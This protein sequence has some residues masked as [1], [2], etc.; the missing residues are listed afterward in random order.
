MNKFILA[1]S[2]LLVWSIL[3]SQPA[4][5]SEVDPDKEATI[6]IE[7]HEEDV[8]G[9]EQKEKIELKGI[10]FSQESD[11]FKDIWV[12]IASPANKEWKIAYEG[13]Y[14]PKLQFIDFNHDKV[15]DILYQSATGGSGGLYHYHLHTLK[16]EK[17]KN[18]PLPESNYTKGKFKDNFTVEITIY[19]SEKPI[20]M[21]VKDRVSDYIRLGIYDSNGKLVEPAS[22]MVDPIAF[23]EPFFIAKKKGYGLKSYQQV[24]GA[25]H[26]DQLGTVE[27]LWYFEK[28]K[29]INLKTTWVAADG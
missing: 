16:N 18:I 17:V 9:D 10:L 3:S 6:K 11:Y 25:Y 21:D 27:T 20:V 12:N 23:F 2:I 4:F 15:K 13:G 14:D 19:P 29:W 7:T 22:V 24:S 1:A 26:A 28:G 5:A 8:T